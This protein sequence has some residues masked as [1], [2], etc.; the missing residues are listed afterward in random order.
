[1]NTIKNP[2]KLLFQSL[3]FFIP[4]FIFVLTLAPDVSFIDSGELA[5]VCIKLGIAHPTGYPLFTVIGN[6]FS[7]F[8]LGEP[9]FRLNLLCAVIGSFASVMFFN[10]IN[11]LFKTLD[12]RFN[13]LTNKCIISLSS[14]LI[15]AFSLTFWNS[16]NAL[17]VYALHILLLISIIYLFLNASLDK[18]NLNKWM[19]F[20]FVLGLGFTNHLTTV[21][22]SVGTLYLF[23]AV[24]GFTE[25]TFKKI[26]AIIIPFALALT[27]YIY[28]PVRAENNVLSW[29]Y[30]ADW[31]SFYRHISG[32]QFS[33][34][35]FSSPENAS[36]QFSYF[37]NSFPKEFFY[38]PLII[39]I[40]GLI[41]IY[42]LNKKIFFYFA[43]L[44][45]FTVL[46]AINYDIYD[47]DSYF[48]LAYIVAGVWIAMGLVFLY[49]K[50]EI[51][52]KYSLL[53][54]LIPVII[55]FQNYNEA[56]ENDNF[57]VRDMTMNVFASA[58]ENAIIMSTQW[59]FWVSASFYYQ[60]IKNIRPDIIVIDKELL[61]R[62][63][64]IKHIKK[65]FPDI[66]NNCKFEFDTYAFELDKF[67][68]FTDRYTNPSSE[69]DRQDLIKIQ[70]AFS[71]LLNA[72]PDKNTDRPFYTTFE[73]EQG[74]PQE[75]F[76]A[77]Y[78]RIPQGLLIRYTKD[79]GFDNYTEPDF[80]FQV[81]NRDDY[82]H[83]F[84]MNAYFSAY[85]SRANY[86]M[87]FSKF[88]EA[89]NLINKALILKPNNPD[90]MRL[91]NKLKELQI[92]K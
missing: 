76:G 80:Q 15:L 7:K 81:S 39:A 5:T 85:L 31:N 84:I 83:N 6:I 49:E 10:L 86:L 24:N 50:I 57:Y 13:S 22:L 32:K 70:K 62:S 21:F 23:F 20:G 82:H 26:L 3:A 54:L 14:S 78:N 43:L 72:I 34:W 40:F 55:C 66:Y 45:L 4:F 58:Q 33:V 8:P 16:A 42:N 75:K 88:Q 44:F 27:V 29:G 11:L 79:K 92:S 67:E 17:E 28:F 18:S 68:K 63:W 69:S 41:K 46:Y 64:Y 71:D 74:A 12:V 52:K 59:D 38:F 73:I 89:E 90:A 25:L 53:F 1:M 2:S 47:I 60:Y 9:I 87:N 56:N 51:F 77:N 61:R 91:L 35:M 65:H 30:P 37:M 36:K 19:L 48:L